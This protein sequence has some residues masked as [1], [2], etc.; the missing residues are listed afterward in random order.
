M[1]RKVVV[2]G[3]GSFAQIVHFYLTHDSPYEV[4]AFTVHESHITQEEMCGLPVVPFE[5]LADRFPPDACD[6]Y[7]AVGYKDV[8][9]VRARICDDAKRR[10]YTLISYVSSRCTRWDG[11]EIGDNCFILEDNTLQPF[12]RIGND[13]VMWSGNHIGHHVTIEDHCFITSHVV[14]SGHVQVGAYS[15]VGVNATVRDGIRIGRAN[16]IGAGALILD[17]TAD[18]A[19]YA[20]RRTPPHALKS[21]DLD[22]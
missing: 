21:S 5:A 11:L 13:V 18:E 6:M 4:A 15:F 22:L 2:F 7:V 19:V 1:S 10:G 3:G 14:I 12:T 20:A 9:R 8:N 16:V 17:S